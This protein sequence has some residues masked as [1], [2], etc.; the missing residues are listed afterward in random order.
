MIGT[1]L[2][3]FVL[4]SI[5]GYSVNVT[6]PLPK[7]FI[8]ALAPHTSN[9]D[10]LLGQLYSRSI[11]TPIGFM[12]KSDWFFWP[13]G[14]VLRRMG[15]IPIVRSR[16]EGVTDQV[17]RQAME[18]DEFRLCITPEGTRKATTEWKRGFYYIALKAQLPILLYGLDYERK[19]IDCHEVIIPSGDYDK[20]IDRIKR[21]FAQ[22]KGK[23][24][25]KF[26]V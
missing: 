22:F 20:D 1:C 18:A 13:L 16:S 5:L 23:Y 24:P 11:D 26:A 17:A 19:V 12:M 7:K 2:S 21:Y 3:R 9:W 10:F 8:A 15:G 4:H 14:K 6:V 25:E